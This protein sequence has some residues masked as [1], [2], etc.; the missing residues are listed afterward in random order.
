MSQDDFITKLAEGLPKEWR[1]EFCYFI[2]TAEADKPFL[3]FLNSNKDAQKA[4]DEAIKYKGAQL[5]TTLSQL[6][7][8]TLQRADIYSRLSQKWR[9]A[10]YRFIEKGEMDKAFENYLDTNTEAQ[11]AVDKLLRIKAESLGDLKQAFSTTSN[12]KSMYEY[13]REVAAALPEE[14]RVSF[15]RFVETGKARQPFL[16]YLE[17]DKN[18]QKAVDTIF[19]RQ[20][21]AF[22]E[23]ARALR[24]DKKPTVSKKSPRP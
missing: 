14:W 4:F 1:A 13:V 23:F 18:A 21:A 2:E 22:E 15:C 9:H 17:S 19:E 16:D 7:D 3:D 24:T 12:R 5:G 8:T 11:I 10:V 20:A 6:F